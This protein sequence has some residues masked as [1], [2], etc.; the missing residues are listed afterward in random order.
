MSAV[1]KLKITDAVVDEVLK[2]W[3][4]NPM[5][6]PRLAKVTVNIGVGESGERLKKAA[7]VL[8]MLTGQEPSERKAKKTIKEFGVRKGEPIAVAVTLRGSKALEFLNKVLDALGRRVKASSFDG[9]G[10]VTIGIKEHIML[11]GVK[12]DPELGIFGMDVCV[13]LER[14]GYRVMRRRV[15]KSRIP[16][17]HRVS[18]VEAMVFFIKELN[19]RVV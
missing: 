19:T 16:R 14:P 12:Y 10:N 7:K 8:Q 3:S 9:F 6:K 2:R 5:L 13:T 17:R 15:K 11:P 4:S 18:K 1:A